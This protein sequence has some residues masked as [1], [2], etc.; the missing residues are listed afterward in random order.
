MHITVLG[1]GVLGVATAWYLANSGHQ[2][3]VI[4]RQDSVAEETSHGNAGMISGI[5]FA[6]GSSGCA[7][8]SNWLDDARLVTIY[9]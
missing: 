6:L 8:Q 9:D 2:V 3:T 5:Q 1:G 7:F 4:D